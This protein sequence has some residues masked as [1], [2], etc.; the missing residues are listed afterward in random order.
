[1]TE[2]CSV[3][4]SSN[5]NPSEI[6]PAAPKFKAVLRRNTHPGC[7]APQSHFCTAHR[8]NV[9]MRSFRSQKHSMH[10]NILQAP[11]DL[12]SR[13]AITCITIDT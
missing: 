9:L 13:N 4:K 1:M 11:S 5:N 7:D 2:I 6:N 8:F 10:W 3:G 12:G